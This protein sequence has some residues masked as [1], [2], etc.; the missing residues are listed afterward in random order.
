M[1]QLGS[2]PECRVPGSHL[3][4][5]THTLPSPKLF[6]GGGRRRKFAMSTFIIGTI[7]VIIAA[8]VKLFSKKRSS[9]RPW[10][11]DEILRREG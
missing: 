10:T 9:N 4:G 1:P 6:R 8:L 3:A 2:D 11:A 5:T 7:I